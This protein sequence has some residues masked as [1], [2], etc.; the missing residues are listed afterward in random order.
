MGNF[1]FEEINLMCIYNTG[2][3]VY[4]RQTKGSDD[5][6]GYDYGEDEEEL[7]EDEAWETEESDAA[8]ADE[9]CIRDRVSTVWISYWMP[10]P[11]GSRKCWWAAL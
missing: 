8:D 5:L 11:T 1:I 10:L 6:D 9:M 3:D 2:R 4:K 7:P